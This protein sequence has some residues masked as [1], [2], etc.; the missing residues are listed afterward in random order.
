MVKKSDKNYQPVEIKVV[1]N[2]VNQA[3]NVNTIKVKVK[4]LHPDAE[5]P[6]YMSIGE[7]GEI[8][9][10][11]MDVK[12]VSKEWNKEINTWVYHTGLAFE[13]PLGYAMLITPRSS[14]RKTDYYIPNT[15]G[16]LDPKYGGELLVNFKQR[17]S[18]EDHKLLME[19]MRKMESIEAA[20]INHYSGSFIAGQLH[21]ISRLYENATCTPEPP[22]QIG[23]RIA[24][25]FIMP[26]PIVEFEEV[27]EIANK[28]GGF[29][30][31]GQ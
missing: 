24:Q 9:A 12:A 3:A 8:M 23:D 25:I 22:Y 11:G 31:T 17:G 5:I 29:G 4:K 10:V 18:E 21:G 13:L 15:P 26:Y 19:L 1:D 2:T 27:E 28:R 20:Y 6:K 14:N 7:N 16:I 30:S